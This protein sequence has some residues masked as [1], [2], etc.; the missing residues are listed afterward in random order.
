MLAALMMEYETVPAIRR[1]RTMVL[2]LTALGIAGMA[3]AGCASHSTD[4]QEQPPE[5]APGTVGPNGTLNNGLMPEQWD[6][7]S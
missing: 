2:A 4:S 3:L 1:A 6:E 7:T 5:T